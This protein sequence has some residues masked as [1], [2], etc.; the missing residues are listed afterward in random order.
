MKLTEMF[1]RFRLGGDKPWIEREQVRFE[2]L[3]ALRQHP[4]F[5][6]LLDVYDAEVV[7]LFEQWINTAPDQQRALRD[8]HAQGRA[9]YRMV[10]RM[11]G[12]TGSFDQAI[13]LKEMHDELTR[14]LKANEV[15]KEARR[16]ATEAAIAQRQKGR[17]ALLTGASLGG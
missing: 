8:L 9:I 16:A 10:K 5:Q 6:A 4:G 7:T 3:A 15:N 12:S 11:D 2:S 17:N 13:K 1:H 14:M